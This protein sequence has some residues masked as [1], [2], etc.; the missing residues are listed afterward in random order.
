METNINTGQE[1]R[2]LPIKDGLL[3]A[4]LFPLEYVRLLGSKCPACGEVTLGTTSSCPNCAG[5]GLQPIPLANNGT[6]WT[7]TVIRNRPPGDFRG[8][9][10]FVPFG[11]GLVELPE[12]IR[13]LAPLGGNIEELAIGMKM[14]FEAYKLYQ[15]SDGVQVIAFRFVPSSP[16]NK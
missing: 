12:G 10:P 2:R 7:Y 3:T 8:P 1:Q 16:A 13:V 6:L 5:S 14:S 11:E 15:N 9:E 4:P